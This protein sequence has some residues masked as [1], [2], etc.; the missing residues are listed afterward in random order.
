MEREREAGSGLDS[1]GE[2]IR[3]AQGAASEPR[4]PRSGG[5]PEL[6][7]AALA[8]RMF[9]DLLAGILVG[10]VLGWGLDELLGTSPWFLTVVGLLGAAGGI[11]LAMRT[12]NE[13]NR[14]GD[15]G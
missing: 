9:A 2:R 6:T 15:R 7:A 11:R 13:A 3:R 12:A 4:R 5:G 10:F 14:N 8:W 1:L